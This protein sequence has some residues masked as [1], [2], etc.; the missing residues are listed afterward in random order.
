MTTQFFGAQFFGAILPTRRASSAAHRNAASSRSHC[1]FTLTVQHIDPGRPEEPLSEGKLVLVDLAGSERQQALLDTQD[2]GQMQD[3]VEINKSLF[4]LRKVIL[5]LSTGDGGGR[6]GLERGGGGKGHVPYRD[7]VLTK[8]LK[9]SL[10][11]NS[12]T[13]MVACVSSND[14]HA[15]ENRIDRIQ[16]SRLC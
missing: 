5:S 1:I 16:R 4:T 14:A 2:R 10:G 7:S 3:S 11:G 9:H 15:E 6:G 12:H 8:L 13:L